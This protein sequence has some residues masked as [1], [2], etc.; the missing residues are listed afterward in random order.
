MAD[1]E[2]TAGG[3]QVA[4]GGGGSIAGGYR[5]DIGVSAAWQWW[6][7]GRHRSGEDGPRWVGPAMGKKAE[8]DGR[9]PDSGRTGGMTAES[10]RRQRGN[11]GRGELQMVVVG[12]LRCSPSQTANST[13]PGGGIRLG[14]AAQVPLLVVA[15]Y[16]ARCKSDINRLKN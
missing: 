2:V 14:H 10:R 12:H 8:V 5:G 1:S 16:H 3:C 9:R 4:W 11:D 7:F 15:I 6:R 13:P